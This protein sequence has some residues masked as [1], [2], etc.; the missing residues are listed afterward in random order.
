MDRRQASPVELVDRRI[1][2][3]R[4]PFPSQTFVAGVADQP[5]GR[6]TVYP[7]NGEVKVTGEAVGQ[8]QDVRGRWKACHARLVGHSKPQGHRARMHRASPAAVPGPV[9]AQRPMG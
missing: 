6:V 9:P 4:S 8:P 3:P 7:Y 1:L 5:A 2:A